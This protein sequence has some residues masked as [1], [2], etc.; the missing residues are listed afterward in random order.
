MN[1]WPFVF[2]IAG[3]VGIVVLLN[4]PGHKKE[5][6]LEA[7]TIGSCEAI[8]NSALKYGVPETLMVSLVNVETPS[9]NEKAVEQEPD[10][11]TGYG[12]FKFNSVYLDWFKTTFGL[13]DP[14]DPVNAADSA[15][16]YLM[17]L[18]E[19]TGSWEGALQA[20]NCG[21]TR[22]SK[23]KPPYTTIRNTKRILAEARLGE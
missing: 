18:Y 17:W 10:G 3:I 4:V 23:G 19:R 5:Q 1:R 14:F 20:W 11:S 7:H 9:W 22:W 2:Y 15:A 13:T 21:Y 8:H 12:I 6:P 16:K